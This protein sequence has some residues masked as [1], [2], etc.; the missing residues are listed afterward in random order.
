[1][2]IGELRKDVHEN[3]TGDSAAWVVGL[4]SVTMLRHSDKP[5]D[6]W[7]IEGV[8][9]PS[10]LGMDGAEASEIPKEGLRLNLRGS[11]CNPELNGRPVERGHMTIILSSGQLTESIPQELGDG[12]VQMQVG[13]EPLW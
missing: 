3:L 1:M 11:D 5:L 9:Q 4:Q 6:D 10:M 12:W 8:E 13:C 7:V 2:V